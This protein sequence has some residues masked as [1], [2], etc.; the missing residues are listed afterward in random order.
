MLKNKIEHVVISG[1]FDN[2][3]PYADNI[4][5]TVPRKLLD[6]HKYRDRMKIF[7]E[8]ILM[9]VYLKDG[10]FINALA[11]RVYAFNGADVP[12]IVDTL[13]PNVKHD[14]EGLER[15]AFP[16][17]IAFNW[18][19]LGLNESADLLTSVAHYYKTPLPACILV[20]RCTKGNIAKGL[21]RERDDFDRETSKFCMIE[22]GR[23]R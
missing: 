4:Y 11:L 9:T 17:D 7:Q 10:R 1:D 19:A 20:N 8:D 21:F 6:A 14:E 13:F 18:Q 15:G 22:T 5:I 2:R 3:I 16:H 12:R 23:W